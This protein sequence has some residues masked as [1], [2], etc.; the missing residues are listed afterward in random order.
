MHGHP[1]LQ[2]PPGSILHHLWLAG[3]PSARVLTLAPDE[4]MCQDV[5]G[6]GG[7]TLRCNPKLTAAYKAVPRAGGAGPGHAGWERCEGR[8]QAPTSRAKRMPRWSSP[9]SLV[10]FWDHPASSQCCAAPP[11]SPRQTPAYTRAPGSASGRDC[12]RSD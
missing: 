3:T 12:C 7:G 10:Q 1:P 6:G 5:R 4:A 11:P 8:R 9:R 2:S